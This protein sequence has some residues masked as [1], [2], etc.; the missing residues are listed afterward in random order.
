MR[1][2]RAFLTSALASLLPAPSG[3]QGMARARD[4]LAPLLA[5]HRVP[6]ASMA[7]IQGGEIAELDAIG[8]DSLTLFEAAS[9]S[10][11]VAATVVLRLAE[12]GRLDLDTPV[13]EMLRSW[14]L[15]GKGAQSVTP[16]LLLC[17][18]AGTPAPGSPGYAVG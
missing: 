12:Q 9:I 8:A 7:L 17:H 3:A 5:R 1:A 15:P 10:K 6:G 2:R 14:K 18:R 4:L 13:N 16:R 11:V